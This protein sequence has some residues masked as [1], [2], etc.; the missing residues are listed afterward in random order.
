[1][2]D[3]DLEINRQ[4]RIV[5]SPRDQNRGKSVKFAHVVVLPALPPLSCIRIADSDFVSNSTIWNKQ[6]AA[7]SLTA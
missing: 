7:S 3:T 2:S 5:N 1:M 4:V 6:F